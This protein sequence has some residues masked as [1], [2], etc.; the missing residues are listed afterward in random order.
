MILRRN[1]ARDEFDSQQQPSASPSSIPDRT[2]LEQA[3]LSAGATNLDI[4]VSNTARE[5]DRIQYVS[6]TPDMARR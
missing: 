5:E 2:S 3:H 6:R 1:T 4:V